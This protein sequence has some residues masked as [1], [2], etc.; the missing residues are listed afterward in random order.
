MLAPRLSEQCVL[1]LS[2]A[3][4]PCHRH[5][6]R[7]LVQLKTLAP[8]QTSLVIVNPDMTQIFACRAC[9]RVLKWLKIK[10]KPAAMVQNHGTTESFRLEK[11]SESIKSNLILSPPCSIT[12]LF[13]AITPHSLNASRDSDATNLPGQPV[14]VPDLSD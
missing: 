3:S 1:L 2:A 10:Q 7:G 8:S 5:P 13:S 14:P 4:A 11:T 6:P 12:I 9:A